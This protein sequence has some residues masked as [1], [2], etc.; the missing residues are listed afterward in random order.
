MATAATHDTKDSKKINEADTFY[1]AESSRRRSRDRDNLYLEG[2]T[3]YDWGDKL[4]FTVGITY[5]TAFSVGAL[6]GIVEGFPKRWNLPKKLILNNFFNAVGRNSTRF[7]NA[8]AAA[9][10]MYCL[11]G[12]GLNFLLEDELA[13]L[14][15][16]QKNIVC[17]MVTGGLYKSTLGI[18]PF[19]V[20]TALGGGA[21]F[22]LHNTIHYLNK[23]NYISFEMKF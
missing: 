2:Y 23:N 13:D 14:T 5:F 3:G 8:S 18:R 15:Q 4:S 12:G 22:L 16:M 1:V 7:A 21:S 6:K 20:G 9:S 11:I 19:V 10:L 17:G